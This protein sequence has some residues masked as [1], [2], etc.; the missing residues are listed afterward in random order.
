M[1]FLEQFVI[2]QSS[3]HIQLLHYLAMLIFFL[4][5]PFISMVFGGTFI[6]LYYRSKGVRE[7]NS[8]Y[9]NFAK[10]VIEIA[11]VNKGMGV[12][13]GIVPLLTSVLIYAQ[14]LHLGNTI[15]VSYLFVSFLLVIIALIFIYTYRYST[16]FNSIFNSIKDVKIEN[17][18]VV[19]DLN[20][21]GNSSKH[22]SAGT[23]YYGLVI[24]LLS[25]WFFI[26]GVTVATFP[27]EWASGSVF[28]VMFSWAVISR[29]LFFITLAFTFTGGTILF[30]YFYWE[31]G[32]TNLSTEYGGFI[33]RSSIYLTLYAGV[34]LPALLVVTLSTLPDGAVSGT[35][36]LYSTIAFLL[37]F[38]SYHLLY[39]MIRNADTNHT[40]LLYLVLIMIIMSMVIKDQLAVDN[41]TKLQTIILSTKYDEMMAQ[42]SG[43]AN[44][45][46]ELNGEEIFQVRCSACHAF[47]HKIVGPPYNETLPKYEGKLNQL[48][49]FILNPQPNNPGYPPMPNPGLAPNEAQAVA[50]YILSTY[51]SK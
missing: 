17:S 31:G 40:G 12:I 29:F 24:L 41:S 13:L 39:S 48:V 23:G 2:P 5:I 51:K 22:L 19:N 42:L 18:N 15:A 35:I 49:A 7:N 26:A 45:V 21:F 14:L 10:E 46:P 38:L 43:E 37:M 3:E 6:S 8:S 16:T 27:K 44:K 50:K 9:L 28:S 34:I 25:S 11:T 1:D 32:R 47:D 20:K 33:R 30:R 36:F 4:F